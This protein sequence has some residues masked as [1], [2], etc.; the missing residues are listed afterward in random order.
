MVGPGEF[1]QFKISCKLWPVRRA[2]AIGLTIAL[3]AEMRSGCFGPADA[4]GGSYYAAGLAG[5][6]SVP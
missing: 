1:L 2:L 6:L 5:I 4:P 3:V